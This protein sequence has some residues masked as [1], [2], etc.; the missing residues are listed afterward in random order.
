MQS[1]MQ[2]FLWQIWYTDKGPIPHAFP[3]MPMKPGL[4]TAEKLVEMMRTD[5]GREVSF[6][7]IEMPQGPVWFGHMSDG[8]TT[9]IICP[10][11]DVPEP[12]K[13]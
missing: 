11:I 4:E 5:P 8:K 10:G 3:A 7:R 1:P 9:Y 13:N 6:T 12:A 2:Y